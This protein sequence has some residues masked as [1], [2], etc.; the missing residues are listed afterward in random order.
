MVI[1]WTGGGALERQVQIQRGLVL[2]IPIELP[3]VMYLVRT[4]FLKADI[5]RFSYRLKVILE[6][7]SF[8]FI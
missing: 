1:I 4:E 2:I 5:M 8:G 7:Y 6:Y 3:K